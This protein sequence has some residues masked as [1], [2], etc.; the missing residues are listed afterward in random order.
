M[1]KYGIEDISTIVEI[2]TEY[3]YDSVKLH[4]YTI[5]I[6][7]LEQ[8]WAMHLCKAKVLPCFGAEPQDFQCSKQQ[9][10]LR[11]LHTVPFLLMKAYG[12]NECKV[13]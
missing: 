4:F 1:I 3:R 11:E 12:N 2:Y 7:A 6:I 9:K 8:K 10:S 13:M 5:Y